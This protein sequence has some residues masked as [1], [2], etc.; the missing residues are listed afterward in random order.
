MFDNQDVKSIGFAERVTKDVVG[1]VT[2]KAA[3]STSIICFFQ[4]T[5]CM[6]V[7]Q[8]ITL[9][10]RDDPSEFIIAHF[11]K[12]S[13]ESLKCRLQLKRSNSLFPC[14]ENDTIT[15]HFVITLNELHAIH[16][17]ALYASGC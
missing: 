16:G 6:A 9:L 8:V 3:S 17:F 1:K 4:S 13:G 10:L 11:R 5:I 15:Y 14:N 7:S 2:K 12:G